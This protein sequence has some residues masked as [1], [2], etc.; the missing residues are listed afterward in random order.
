MQTLNR[1]DFPSETIDYLK[2]FGVP[3]FISLQGFLRAPDVKV[4]EN[5]TIKLDKFDGLNDILSDVSTI[6]LDEEEANIIDMDCGVDEIVITDGSNGSRIVFLD[7][8]KIS[9]VR[10]DDIVD[11]TGCGDTYMAAYISQR[12]CSK[13]PKQAGEFASLIAS[14]KLAHIGPFKE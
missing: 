12:L 3:I 4:N 14:K 1:N 8:I 11:A 7:E 13:S 6:F 2:G 9:P 10:C 5:Y